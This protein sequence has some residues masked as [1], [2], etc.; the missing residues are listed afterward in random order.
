VNGSD[1]ATK[2]A[3]PAPK[4][5]RPRSLGRWAQLVVVNLVILLTLGALIEGAA[6]GVL[7]VY[8][9]VFRRA[10]LAERKHTEYDEDLGWINKP[11]VSIPNLYGPGIALNT[12]SLRLRASTEF[13]TSVPAGKVRIVCS[14]DSFTLGYGVA[15][16][17]TWCHVLSQLD[18]RLETAN[19]GQGGYGVDQ[20]YL[21]YRRDGA[22]LDHDMQVF[23]FITYD[24]ERMMQARFLGYPKP[25]LRIRDAQLV[26]TN[27][28]VPRGLST[29]LVRS[30]SSV[31]LELR[32]TR[33]LATFSR[34]A[35]WGNS[36]EDGVRETEQLARDIVS[37]ILDDLE[38]LNEERN[39]QLVLVH[40]PTAEDYLGSS[41][42]RWR[43]FLEQE[44]VRRSIPYVYLIEELRQLPRERLTQ[45]FI[46]RGAI[47]HPGAAGHYTAEG[48]DFVAD[49]LIRR[50]Q[51]LA[52]LD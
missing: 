42:G 15:D 34:R 13:S 44:A 5:E 51:Q 10:D 14:G 8:N 12:N 2:D 23:A 1:S 40:L 21:W 24:F 43:S 9:G 27:V 32:I 33:L 49:G 45:L 22:R 35:G 30:L 36:E 7:V 17:E 16:Q 37:L 46:P 25:L 48:H 11:N 41:S 38:R 26:T 29:G 3:V 50:L 39:S 47:D 31:L 4:L 20:A 52:P 28:P 19:M 18:T 6:S